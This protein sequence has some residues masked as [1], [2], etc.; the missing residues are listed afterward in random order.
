MSPSPYTLIKSKTALLKLLRALD[1]GEAALDIETTSLAPA[2]GRVRLV[3]IVNNDGAWIID[4]DRIKGGFNAYAKEFERDIDWIVF[5]SGF[6]MRWFRAAGATPHIFDVQNQRKAVLG[7]GRYSLAR[8]ADLDLG[9]TMNK[10]QQTSDWS[11]KTLTQEQLDYAILDAQIT[12]ELWLYWGEQMDDGQRDCAALLDA[13]TLPVIEMEDTGIM[14][15]PGHHR[16][17][18]SSWEQQL[19]HYH[20]EVRKHLPS[21]GDGPTVVQNL[22]S[23]S[24]LADVFA[25]IFSDEVLSIW[26]RTEKTGQL[27][28]TNEALT[29]IG[30]IP[31]YKGSPVQELMLAL[32]RFNRVDKYLSSFGES[33]CIMAAAG[34]AGRIHPSF[35]IGAA[36]T[37]RFSSSRPNVQQ[38]PRD[39]LLFPDDEHMTRVRRSFIAA[40]GRLLVSYDYSA[41]ELR[42]LA[43]LAGDEQLLQ[44]VVYGDVHNEV[45]GMILGRENDKS[46]PEGKARRSAAKAVSFGIIYGSGAG[47]LSLTMGTDTNSAQRYIAY[48]QERYSAAFR[49]RHLIMDEAMQNGGFARMVDGGTIWMGKRPEMPECANYPVQRGAWS[50][51]AEALIEHYKTLQDIDLYYPEFTRMSATIHDAMMDETHED[52]AET[53]ARAMAADMTAGY[54]AVFPGAPTENLLEGGAGS[55]WADLEDV[56]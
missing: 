10:E 7:G 56:A 31:E 19:R 52:D 26:P 16:E 9:V 20:D 39:R 51:M 41:I 45:A 28:I 2:D 49:Y 5:Y 29:K 18:V 27:Q 37:L 44:D 34:P 3:Q 6:E 46:T 40:P 50:I 54:L 32:A 24:Q 4:F 13:L 35:N 43:L 8:M 53:V 15:D 17:L 38:M 36:R 30:N 23:K 47:G 14:F 33:L 1:G 48:W 11:A 25:S 22:R 12:W 55:N 21:V 42:V